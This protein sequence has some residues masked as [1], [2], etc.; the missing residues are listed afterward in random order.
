VRK[1]YVCE[2]DVD[3][4]NLL[5]LDSGIVIAVPIPKQF[6]YHDPAGLESAIVSKLELARQR[7][8]RGKDVTP[9]LLKEIAELTGGDSLKASIC[10]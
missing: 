9:F 5:K 3:A 8:I 4:N 1:L 6:A 7:G 2:P 10:N